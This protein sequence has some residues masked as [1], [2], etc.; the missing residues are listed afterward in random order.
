MTQ[1]KKERGPGA[2]KGRR[3]ELLICAAVVDGKLV[4]KQYSIEDQSPGEE[5]SGHFPIDGALNEFES[6]FGKK[7]DKYWDHLY[8]KKSALKNSSSKKPNVSR[9]FQGMKLSTDEAK[10]AIYNGWKGVVFETVGADQALFVFTEE[11]NPSGKK[12]N[13]PNAA[14]IKVKDLEF[15]NS[16][17]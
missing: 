7:P 15:I 2:P 16:S 6:E 11:I 1:N 13:P 8:L 17:D 14:Q 10:E 5:G 4:S 12:K 3:P 9:D